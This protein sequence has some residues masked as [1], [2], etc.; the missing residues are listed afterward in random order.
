MSEFAPGT[1]HLAKRSMDQSVAE[2]HRWAESHRLQRL[3]NAGRQ[4]SQR[5]YSRSLAW[6][7]DRLSTWGARLQERH[8]TDGSTPTHQ[9]A[10]SLA[11]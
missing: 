1:F 11:N 5:F 6:L 2:A 3:A 10:N 4:D 7:G 9:S 8:A